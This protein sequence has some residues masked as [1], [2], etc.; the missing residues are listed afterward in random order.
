MTKGLVGITVGALLAGVTAFA[1]STDTSAIDQRI[2]NQERRIQEGINSGQLNDREANRL[3]RR[4]EKIEQ[5]EARAKADGEVTAKER[6]RLNRAL[7]HNSRTIH[8][9]KHDRQQR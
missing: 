7:D 3:D 1:Q 2:Q 8:K 6:R 5:A 4:L 9:E